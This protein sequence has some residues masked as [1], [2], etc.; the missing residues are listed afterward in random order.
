MFDDLY[1]PERTSSLSQMVQR[2]AAPETGPG[3]FAGF[4]GALADSVPS[5]ALTAGSAWSALL[6]AY[7]KAAAYRDAPTVAMINGEPAPDMDKL[8]R[9]TIDQMGNSETAR[10]FRE[11]AKQFAPDPAAVGVAGQVVH[12]LVST[13]TKAV[14][15]SAATGPA[16]PLVFGGDMGINRAQELSDQGVDSATA[17]KAGI[18]T[19]IVSAA[20]LKL[21]PALGA[22]RLQSAAIGAGINP[23]M[24]IAERGTIHALL[25]HADYPTIAAQYKPFDPTQLAIEALAGAAFGGI[26]HS[27][28]AREGATLTPDEHAAT[29]VMNEVRARD[30]DTL[31]TPGDIAAANQAHDA[32]LLARGQLDAGE[33]VSVAHGLPMDEARVM[34]EAERVANDIAPA[35][36]DELLAQRTDLPR[37]KDLSPEHRAIEAAAYERILENPEQAVAEYFGKY[38]KTI[39]PEQVK[40]LFPEFL[41]DQSLAAA[42]HEPSSYLSKL[43]YAEA[44]KQN[45]G[46]PV[47]FTA[48][49]GGSGKSEARPLAMETSGIQDGGIVFDSTLSSFDSARTKID[50]ALESGAPVAIIYTNRHVE[51]AFKFAMSRER[52]VPSKT[53]AAAHVGASNTI[54]A[55]AERYRDNPNVAIRVVNN[56]G[57]LSKMHL[58]S[59]D[60]VFQYDHNHIERRLYD[61]ASKAH[62]SGSID[63]AKR[64]ALLAGYSRSTSD[65][66][67]REVQPG[68][69]GQDLGADRRRAGSGTQSQGHLSAKAFPIQGS[70]AAAV[71][72]RGSQIQTKFV[73][74]EADSLIT[75]HDN[76]LKPNPKF[77]ADLQP[78]DR[79]RAASETQITK[80]ENGINPEL[81]AGSPKAADGA[82][83]IGTDKVVES[84]NAR[85]IALRRAY[86]S[87]KAEIYRDWLIDNADRFGLDPAQVGK[88][89]NPVLARV[90]VS[91]YD[92]AEFA[93]QANESAVAHMS[94]TE[95]AK[96]DAARI[97][98]LAGLSTNDDGTI[99]VASSNAFI[100]SFME[101]AVSPSEHGAMITADGKLSQQGLQRIRNAVFAKAYGDPEIVAMMAE[102]TDANV[103]NI[104]SG[105]LRAAPAV[106]KLRD[107]IEAGARYPMDISTDLIQAVRLFSQLRSDGMTV[108]QML[109]QHGLFDSGPSPEVKN[110]LVGLEENAKAPKRIAEMIGRYVD[111]VDRLGD[112]RQQGIF[113]HG[114]TPASPDLMNKSIESV[115]ADFDVKTTADLFKSPEIDAAQKAIESNP[116]MTI[117]LDDGTDVRAADVLR[118]AD[119]EIAKA[120]TEASGFKAA[121]E[122]AVRFNS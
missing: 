1:A 23:V 19:G 9:E 95:T 93:R 3:S 112:P 67:G 115:R 24:G 89:K 82:P 37:G 102:S 7:G 91:K 71:T 29:L 78:R 34:A 97:H 25:D 104:L 47:I 81:L 26:F 99:N 62:E 83:I 80:I 114:Q 36:R 72:E 44:L 18:V 109:A 75:S 117:R 87:G 69:Q 32:Q 20:G 38:G 28:K 53:L 10:A 77:P 74:V 88:L 31:T 119:A 64:D 94:V 58:G 5:A 52:V 48:G 8:K 2:P 68:Q 12:G 39:D 13:L 116:D 105:L 98:D 113:D 59:L 85:T 6:D 84:G 100:R 42:V 70:E 55:L 66:G 120:N 92:R 110:I 121:I 101:S 103:K 30:A 54:R 65:G 16:A 49:G 57:D 51:G 61:L 15:Y 41:A 60:D 90:G 45:G 118:E 50:Q 79:S 107:L 17:A 108:K 63:T 86:D 122:C 11:K 35:I 43:I 56:H 46:Q 22:T 27:T 4:G 111:A 40:R 96:S 76:A 73:A 33:A 106:A 14:A 21:P